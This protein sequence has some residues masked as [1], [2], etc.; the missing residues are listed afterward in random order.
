MSRGGFDNCS[1]NFWLTHL[2]LHKKVI[3]LNGIENFKVKLTVFNINVFT[4]KVKGKKE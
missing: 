2:N 1:P 3:K 4:I